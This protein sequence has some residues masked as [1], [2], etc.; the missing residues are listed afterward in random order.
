[1]SSVRTNR[2]WM[3]RG[4]SGSPTILKSC[5]RG[6]VIHRI[7]S[8]ILDNFIT[9]QGTKVLKNHEVRRGFHCRTEGHPQ[10]RASPSFIE[11]TGAQ[12]APRW[13]DVE[14]G[15]VFG[16][17]SSVLG[18]TEVKQTSLRRCAKYAQTFPP[19]R[20]RRSSGKWAICI[21]GGIM[22]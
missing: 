16:L 6:F 20:V 9:L 1:M 17:S 4:K 2:I 8:T 11:Y 5:Y 15:N 12:T 13:T 18:D 10:R 14:L 22:R 7:L 3:W 21:T 19:P